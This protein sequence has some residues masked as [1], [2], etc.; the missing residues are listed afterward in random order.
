ML[1]FKGPSNFDE[2]G[3]GHGL[4]HFFE[5]MRLN[6]KCIDIQYVTRLKN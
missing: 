6:Q 1:L 3:L 4:S 2:N 5:E